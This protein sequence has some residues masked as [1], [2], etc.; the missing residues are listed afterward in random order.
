MG[1]SAS[2]DNF[3]RLCCVVT[4]LRRSNNERGDVLEKVQDFCFVEEDKRLMC[5]VGG[6]YNDPSHSELL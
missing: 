3:R 4:E 1:F 5:V 2:K 6:C